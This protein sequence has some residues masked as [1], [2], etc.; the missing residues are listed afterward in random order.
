MDILRAEEELAQGVDDDNRLYDLVLAQT[1]SEERA[2]KALSKRI[3]HRL[4]R[5]EDISNYEYK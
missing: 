1:G 5:G 2:S 4:R 3:G